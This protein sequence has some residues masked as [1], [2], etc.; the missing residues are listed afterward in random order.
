MLFAVTN[1]DALRGNADI[2]KK[3]YGTNLIAVLKHNAYSSGMAACARALADSTLA[4]AVSSLR[5]A[6][7]LLDSGLN[8]ERIMVLDPILPSEL[9][10]SLAKVIL[11]IDCL[12][13]MRAL[14]NIYINKRL[15]V[16]LRIDLCKSGIG[17]REEVFDEAL[18]RVFQSPGMT[19]YGIFAHVPSLYRCEDI[20]G[21]SAR[22]ERLCQKTRLIFP[23]A[24]C[25][26]ATSASM[27]YEL[28]RFDACRVGTALYGLPS[29]EG[30]DIAPLRPVL[31]LHSSLSRVFKCADSLSFYESCVNTS[32]ITTAGIVS[33]G[34]GSLP[35]LLHKKE[36]A[37]LVCDT[38]VPVIG[39][40]CMGHMIVD[41]SEVPNSKVGDEVIIV[42][43][44]QKRGITAASFARSCGVS[45][46]RCDG[47]LFVT[48]DS[49]RIFIDKNNCIVNL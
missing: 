26:M 36:L 13:I 38:L 24:V 23:S 40:P 14:D 42:G 20:R 11:P 19:L 4:L 9:N 48:E 27:N 30:Q 1:L 25:H 35:A 28:L 34:Y 17:L 37:V 6:G 44:M 29:R 49:A 39:S 22:F 16:Q 7:I 21:M 33:T 43:D 31:S 5:E 45:A 3:K 41:L 2:I 12:E 32:A 47:S 8:A 18:T 10:D 15:R 46:C